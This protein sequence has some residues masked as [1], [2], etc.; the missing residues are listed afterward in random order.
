[1]QE[2]LL[3]PGKKGEMIRHRMVIP[4]RSGILN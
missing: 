3:F 4:D 2:A 1:M